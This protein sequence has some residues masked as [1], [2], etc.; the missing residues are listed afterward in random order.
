MMAASPNRGSGFFSR[1]RLPPPKSLRFYIDSR[2]WYVYIYSGHHK[3]KGE[4]LAS[5]GYTLDDLVTR[6]GLS[7]RQIRYY[8]TRKLVP[9]AGQHR[10][11]NAV[12]GAVTLRRL[13]KIVQLKERP[14][15]PTARHLSLEEIRYEL[16]HPQTYAAPEP[17]TASILCEP[18]AASRYLRDFP[19]SDDEETVDVFRDEPPVFSGALCRA[20]PDDSA[21]G[22]PSRPLN[23]LLR[24]LRSLLDSLG[25]DAHGSDNRSDGQSWQRLTSPEVEIQ[26]RI[27]DTMKARE[28]LAQMAAEIGDL[29]EGEE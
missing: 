18:G 20:L 21:A 6:T 24:R 3:T 8:I 4:K 14:T 16:D 26:V 19:L 5:P 27:P 11:P 1:A 28:R 7:K 12:Y 9:G 22:E 13:Q 23:D 15:G 25:L 17:S 10:G 29:L 2:Q